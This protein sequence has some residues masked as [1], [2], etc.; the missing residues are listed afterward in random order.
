M[1]T[2]VPNTQTQDSITRPPRKGEVLQGQIG[3][4]GIVFE[5]SQ[6][7]R[8]YD[9][10]NDKDALRIGAQLA[11]LPYPFTLKQFRERRVVEIR[12]RE[13]YR[14]IYPVESV[15]AVFAGIAVLAA[16]A[17]ALASKIKR[18]R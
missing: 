1:A 5:E 3:E 4:Y 8:W 12:R 17:L 11:G 13:P 2:Q 15:N 14:R 16:G 6:K 7:P 10:R 18:R 9:A